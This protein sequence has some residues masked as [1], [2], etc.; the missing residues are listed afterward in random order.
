VVKLLVITGQQ[1]SVLVST[2]QQWS[3]LVSTGQQW[4]SAEQMYVCILGQKLPFSML[5]ARPISVDQ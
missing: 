1:W 2:G 3:V 4:L 5:V